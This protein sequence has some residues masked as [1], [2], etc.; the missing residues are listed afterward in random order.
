MRSGIAGGVIHRG[1]AKVARSADPRGRPGGATAEGP[2]G[3]GAQAQVYKPPG[4]S[5]SL[6]LVN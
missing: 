2:S 1:E 4:E 5:S 6:V 3:G